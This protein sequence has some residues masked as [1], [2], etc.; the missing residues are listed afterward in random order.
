MTTVFKASAQGHLKVVK[1]LIKAQASL[2]LRDGRLETPLMAAC[3]RGQLEVAQCLLSAG[4]RKD[5]TDEHGR[6]ALML[7]STAGHLEVVRLLC[8]EGSDKEPWT[9]SGSAMG[10]DAVDANGHTALHSAV[11]HAWDEVVKYLLEQRVDKDHF[12]DVLDQQGRSCLHEAVISTRTF[13][14]VRCL[15][16]AGVDKHR[17]DAEGRTP[18]YEAAC[19]GHKTLGH[20]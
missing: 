1:L 9:G 14:L 6:T 2:E 3:S 5:E 13:G 17:A 12:G 15:V 19:H 18:L 4:C 8:E 16:D 7:A 10:N 20:R 11:T